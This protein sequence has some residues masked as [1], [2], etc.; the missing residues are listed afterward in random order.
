MRE[1]TIDD[2]KGGNMVTE[3]RPDVIG[4]PGEKPETVDPEKA[5]RNMENELR[6]MAKSLRQTRH[7]YVAGMITEEEFQQVEAQFAE[8]LKAQEKLLQLLRSAAQSK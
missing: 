1:S 3:Y 4:K 6:E 2:C 5:I 8:K 7:D